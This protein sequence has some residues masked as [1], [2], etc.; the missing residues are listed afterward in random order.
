MAMQL[1]VSQPDDPFERQAD[2]MA[3]HIL[4]QLGSGAS[5]TGGQDE[6]GIEEEGNVADES[7]T[8]STT[9][10]AVA[11]ASSGATAQPAS[12]LRPLVRQ[13]D[14]LTNQLTAQYGQ[15]QPLA[16]DIRS[17]VEP[18]LGY[19][20]S[21][22]RL[23]PSAANTLATNI[24]ARAFTLDRNIYFR[25]GEYQP[26]SREGMHT[27]L[28]ELV[29]TTQPDSQTLQRVPSISAWSFRNSGATAAANCCALCPQTLGVGPSNYK[30]AMELRATIDDDEVGATYDIKR[31]KERS[32]W[33]R[34]SGAWTNLTH[35]GPGAD[36]DSHNSDECLTPNSSP[37][38]IYSIDVPGFNGSAG[39]DAAATD[40]V[41]KATFTEYVEI[42]TT[43]GGTTSGNTFD[44]HSITW[45]TQSGG[46][47]SIDAARSEIASGSVTVG[48]TAP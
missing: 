30:N 48:T 28:H 39:F 37:G 45:V 13:A 35:V 9:P 29:H 23:Y 15:G 41:Y 34:V 21:T 7:A 6:V 17:R 32:T 16:P 46:T 42:M 22:V 2:E 40:M 25:N 1:P 43:N 36:D 4:A 14:A 18:L 12:F 33:K 44:W 19:D 47:W 3:N 10:T 26:A 38:H 8:A 27:L 5:A 31:T 24:Q 20:L 11:P